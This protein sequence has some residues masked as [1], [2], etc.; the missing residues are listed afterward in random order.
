MTKVDGSLKALLQGVSQQPPRDRLS[1]QCTE[2]INMTADPVAG[3]SRRAP[4]DLVGALGASSDVRGFHNF[5]MRNGNKFLAFFRDGGIR[6]TDYNAVQYPVTVE[7]AAGAYLTTVGDLACTTVEDQV[8]VVNKAVKTSM[9]A[10]KRGYVNAGVGSLGRMALI[11]VRGGAY[12]REYS[13][14]KDGVRIAMFRTP[15]GSSPNMVNFTRTE[16]IASKLYEALTTTVNTEGDATGAG[17]GSALVGTAALAATATWEVTRWSDII[18]IRN[19]V[20]NKTYTITSS[21][22]TGGVN[23]KTVQD[24][25]ASVEDL[26]PKAPHG[27]LAR[28]AT[29]NDPDEDMLFEFIVDGA[30]PGVGMGTGF[31]QPGYWQETVSPDVPYKMNKTT[32]PHILEYKE[33]TNS[34]VFR[35]GAWSDRKVG[36]ALTNPDPSFIGNT[37]NDVS[38]FQGRLVFLSGSYVCMGRTNRFN[39]F[40]MGSA[41]QLVDTD[42]IDISSTAVE[43]STMQAAVPNNRDLVVFSQKGQFLVFGRTAITPSNATLVLTTTFEAELRAKPTAAGRNV[44]FATN[45]GR[46]TGI[47]EFYSEGNADANDARLITQHVKQYIVGQVHRLISSSNYDMLMV[48]TRED[49]KLVYVYQY[50]WQNQEKMQSAWSKWQLPH[51]SVFS[52]FDE[53]LIYFVLRQTTSAGVEHFLYRMSLDIYAENQVDYPIFLDERFDVNDCYKAFV[54][55]YNRQAATGLVVV[56]GDGCPNPGLLAPVQ[57]IVYDTPNNRYVVTLRSDMQGGNVVCGVPFYSEYRPTMPMIKDRSGVV[58]GTGLFRIKKFIL[59]L[60]ATGHIIGQLI[61]KFGDGEPVEFQGRIIGSPDNRIGVAAVVDESFDMPFR[62]KVD[63]ADVKYYT[64]RHLPMTILDIEWVGQYHKSGKRIE[65]G[66]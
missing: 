1:G 39:D 9:L 54:L 60:Q 2:M 56:Q 49:R 30:T 41:G 46:F 31:G 23:M 6:V 36:T 63:R 52:F 7:G 42:P 15:N 12:G 8:I 14:F 28:V 5:E 25:V 24:T 53:E 32:F 18:S 55:P 61:S 57:S 48:Q 38:T 45:Y 29:E 22:D 33:A 4:T 21:D 34:F 3:L 47:R 40:W 59:T 27:Y 51:E 44:F 35:Q 66:G 58:V 13:I 19:K 43:A 16:Y 64:D 11:Y 20:N 50:I 17:A 37:I 26:P 10:D 65:T 62:E